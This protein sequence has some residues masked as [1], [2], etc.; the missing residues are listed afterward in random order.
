MN[1][2]LELGQ[3]KRYSPNDWFDEKWYTSFYDD[4]KLL[5]EDGVFLNGLEHYIK[6]GRKEGRIPKRKSF[7]IIRSKFPGA[8]DPIGIHEINSLET[9][10]SDISVVYVDIDRPRINFVLPTFDTDIMFGGYISMVEIIKKIKTFGFDIRFIICEDSKMSE[11]YFW[12]NLEEVLT[13]DDLDKEKISFQNI[14]KDL[15][16]EVSDNDIFIAY[17]S[18]TALIAYNIAKH[19][20][21]KRVIYLIQEDERIFYTNNSFRALI[22]YVYSLPLTFLFNTKDLYDYFKQKKIGPFREVNRGDYRAYWFDPPITNVEKPTISELFNRKSKR[23]LFYA[24]PEAHASRNLFPMGIL[25]LKRAI[26]KEYFD[27]KWS[28][29]GIGAAKDYKVNLS[30]GK[31]IDI[32]AKMSLEEYKKTLKD[33][34]IGLFLMY[35]PHPGL[36]SFEMAAAGMIVVVNKFE[37]RDEEY[38]KNKS[39]N[40]IVADPNPDSIAE[41]LRKA[42][43]KSSYIYERIQNAYVSKVKSWDEALS[44]ELI[45]KILQLED[46]NA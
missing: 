21:I 25:A 15:P 37:Y 34:D 27:D 4:V 12:Y 9:K 23:V 42:I 44:D 40:F 11:D 10:L 32:K 46:K 29:H 36:V 3:K 16:I 1:I 45:R 30:K 24:R 19:T 20:A 5:I 7:D 35:A 17:S 41:A 14:L 26:E 43:I 33:Y 28:F 2:I 22:D 39:K 31:I 6:V 18:M 38:F 8:I 13:L